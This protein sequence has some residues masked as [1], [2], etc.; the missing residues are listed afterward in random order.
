MYAGTWADSG[1]YDEEWAKGGFVK[2]LAF[3]RNET[4]EE[5]EDYLLELYGRDFDNGDKIT[6]RMP[7]LKARDTRAIELSP[8]LLAVYSE[9]YSYLA[10]R[11]IIENVQR[12]AGIRYDSKSRA[13]VIPWFDANGRLRNVKYR[14]VYG[15]TFWYHRGAT[16][17]RELVYGIDSVWNNSAEVAV[18]EEA[19]IDALCWRTVGAYGIAVGGATF[20]NKQADIIKRSPIKTLYI[21]G[22][23]DKA[24]HKFASQAFDKL[25][26]YVD[27]RK[28]DK[29]QGIKDTNEAL[30]KGEN[31]QDFLDSSINV[32]KLCVN[33]TNITI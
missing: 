19:E 22:D 18:L 17:V 30:M 14:T 3:L 11:G 31:I 21:S 12:L 4:Y 20:T 8:T 9:D 33:I 10:G 27:I 32:D 24:G 7:K 13:V 23:N 28:I 1:A 25:R 15:K 26:R 6:L 16:P 29:P 5:A 2:L